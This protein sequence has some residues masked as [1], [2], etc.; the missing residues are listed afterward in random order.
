MQTES[1]VSSVDEIIDLIDK[2]WKFD[3][4][5]YPLSSWHDKQDLLELLRKNTEFQPIHTIGIDEDELE[6]LAKEYFTSWKAYNT[7]Q[8]RYVLHGFKQGYKAANSK[9]CFSLE[10]GREIWKAGQE[11]WKTSGASITFEELSEKM[12]PSLSKE[13]GKKIE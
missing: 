1:K 12:I 2:Y 8:W 9:G 4:M 7:E 13:N 6:R 3:N 5:Q 10:Q 11:Y